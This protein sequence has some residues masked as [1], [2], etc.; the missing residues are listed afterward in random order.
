MIW[1]FRSR[2]PCELDDHL[3]VGDWIERVLPSKYLKVSGMLGD[4]VVGEA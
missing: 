2:A 1:F 4:W 3:L